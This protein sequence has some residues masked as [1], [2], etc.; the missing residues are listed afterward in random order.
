[1]NIQSQ[2]HILWAAVS[3]SGHLH[4]PRGALYPCPRLFCWPC[5]PLLSLLQ[6][7]WGPRCQALRCALSQKTRRR[8][9]VPMCS[10]Q[11]EMKRRRRWAALCSAGGARITQPYQVIV[12]D[13]VIISEWES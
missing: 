10:M 8:R 2:S 12:T 7:P 3:L 5:S 1:M 13:L 4:T 9:A 6:V 11:K